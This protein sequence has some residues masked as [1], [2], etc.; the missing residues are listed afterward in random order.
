[1]ICEG[2]KENFAPRRHNQRF[3][4]PKCQRKTNRPSKDWRA[5]VGSGVSGAYAEL[6][7]SAELLRLGYWVFRNVTPHGPCDLIALRNGRTVRVE[8]K[9][10][11]PYSRVLPKSRNYAQGTDYDVLALVHYNGAMS[12]YPP[13]EEFGKNAALE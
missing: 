8:V 10:Q 7:V 4:A 6:I 3:C 1:M 11:V 5:D 12:F 9:T 13:L 2:C